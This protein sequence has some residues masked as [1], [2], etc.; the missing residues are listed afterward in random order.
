MKAFKTRI[1]LK[2]LRSII[3]I[4][5]DIISQE[6][7]III[8]SESISRKALPVKMERGKVGGILNRYADTSLIKNEKDN[9]WT[10]IIE[11][12]HGLL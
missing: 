10:K 2:D 11:D 7:E 9:A 3:D 6:V 8:L 12:K 1:K 4:P 5:K